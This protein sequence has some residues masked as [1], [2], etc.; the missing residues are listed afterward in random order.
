MRA[1]NIFFHRAAPPHPGIP[2]R[3]RQRRHG[4][5]RALR[6]VQATGR[7]RRWRVAVPDADDPGELA[8]KIFQI[9]S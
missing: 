3:R 8:A 2:L 1:K 7:G 5:V 9:R 4:P 6:A